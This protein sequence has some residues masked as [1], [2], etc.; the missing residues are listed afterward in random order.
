M[1]LTSK[2][3]LNSGAGKVFPVDIPYSALLESGYSSTGAVATDATIALGFKPTAAST[4]PLND[5]TA[6]Y[7]LT[8]QKIGSTVR[9]WKQGVEL[10][11]YT[12][13]V[14]TS[15]AAF[16]ISVLT[17]YAGSAKGYYSRLDVVEQE[18]AYTDFWECSD[19]VT[20]L[21]VAKEVILPVFTIPAS[22]SNPDGTGNRTSTIITSE[23]GAPFKTGSLATLING[24]NL[25]DSWLV[26]A[27]AT[28]GSRMIWQ[29]STP[30]IIT[31][32]KW[33]QE[34]GTVQGVWK[35]QGSNDGVEWTDLSAD[36]TLGG[37]A[38]SVMGDLSANT[39]AFPYYCI[40]GVSG[41]TRSA[42]YTYEVTFKI[43]DA[44][45]YTYGPGGGKY[46]F[47]DALNLGEDSSGNG[48]NWTVNGTQ[49]LDT[50]TNNYCTLN[51]LHKYI[52]AGTVSLSEGNNRVVAGTADYGLYNGAFQLP[53][54][55]K[56]YWEQEMTGAN[57]TGGI[58]A[59]TT[60]N[61]NNVIR[62]ETTALYGSAW[63]TG[64]S[65]LS[66]IQAGNIMGI[67]YDADAQTV[68][69][70]R[71]NSDHGTPVDLSSATISLFPMAGDFWNAQ[72]TDSTLNFGA[73]GFTYTPPTGF[74]ALNTTNLP[75][76]TILK[77]STVA[78]FVTRVGTGDG[79]TKLTLGG[80]GVE[81]VSRT[82]Q[83]SSNGVYTEDGTGINDGWHKSASFSADW[84]RYTFT[85][86][87]I[88]DRLIVGNR[89]DQTA[90]NITGGTIQASHDGAAW[91]TLGTFS[92]RS[93]STPNRTEHAFTNTTAYKYYQVSSPV[94]GGKS[95]I[96]VSFLAFG[97]Y[98]ET[99]VVLP[100]MEGGPDFVST[101]STSLSSA[102][103]I[104]DTVR[105]AGV[106]IYTNGSG[107][108]Y[109]N[110]DGMQSFTSDGYTLGSGFNTNS[111]TGSFLDL[112]LKAG[113]D[114]GFE[115]QVENSF[116]SGVTRPHSL[117]KPITFAI[118]KPLTGTSDWFVCHKD[119]PADKFLRLN[120][121]YAVSTTNLMTTNTSTGFTPDGLAGWN[122]I[123]MV[124]YLF[125]D[126][127][128]FKAFSYIGN[129]VADG[130]FA[131]L[132][133][134][135]LSVPFLKNVDVDG[136][137][138]SFHT[139][140]SPVN[141]D[142]NY[143]LPSEALAQGTSGAFQRSYTSNGIKIEATDSQLNGSGNLHVGLAIL[144][145]T[146]YSNSY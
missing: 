72:A 67:C 116:A 59:D 114:Q 82:S 111:D 80:L 66:A 119:L 125:T 109:D 104:N 136:Y 108:E 99:E 102:W 51:P 93:Q 45:E 36:F 69:F 53:T 64:Q 21:W 85:N 141:P 90:Y 86:P 49:T 26:E 4:A 52:N 124:F 74:L 146:K 44:V 25:T 127:D 3:V 84:F 98:A 58:G 133:G 128:I 19:F 17:A 62:F 11:N 6:H 50:P 140:T 1:P 143:L 118:Y 24:T 35:W 142:T 101:K 103:V 106:E 71:Q 61:I 56:W 33:F 115:I 110:P 63:A 113:V 55:G 12:G 96:D 78:D 8:I 138:H 46:Y 100:D 20:G 22:Y 54:S 131:N 57:G 70:K 18:M 97:V 139:A 15:N 40:S 31:E 94:N 81:S 88:C 28:I 91:D 75:D 13:G 95:Y 77:S 105:G 123:P 2:D 30:R 60:I 10:A 47:A 34:Y 38:L 43:T 129:G 42:S 79:I 32:A 120:Q 107:A 39:E 16:L 122:G 23:E 130:P 145:S 65:G 48:N 7:L 83:Y 9:V 112:C 76:P 132:G 117:G 137:W 134:K 29:F 37:A 89:T 121:T 73:T 68:Q 41:V 14:F 135:L 27:K 92:G 144:E 87:Q 126:S 5:M